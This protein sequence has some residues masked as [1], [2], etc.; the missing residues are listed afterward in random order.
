MTEEFKGLNLIEL[1]DLLEEASEPPP[2]S[3]VPQ[4]PGWIIL[5]ILMIGAGVVL[6]RFLQRRH[7]A[8]AYRRAALQQLSSVQSDPA[9]IATILRRTALVAY[10]RSRVA[11]LAGPEWL[12]FLDHSFSG[13]GFANG[14]GQI[15]AKAPFQ[16]IPSDPAATELARTW[17][18]QHR[19]EKRARG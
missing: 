9:A 11:N 6:F 8:N 5:G 7:R 14:P 16:S 10:P 2:I 17:I 13:K 12:T 15:F 1:I 18:K 3:L 19:V 4:T